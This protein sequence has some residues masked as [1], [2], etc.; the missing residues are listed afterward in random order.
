LL[1]ILKLFFSEQT[2]DPYAL[3][4]Q[5]LD[6]QIKQTPKRHGREPQVEKNQEPASQC[7]ARLVDIVPEYGLKFLA[8][9]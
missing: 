5:L 8:G 7:D 3:A 2:P 9:E 6:H 4:R 1:K